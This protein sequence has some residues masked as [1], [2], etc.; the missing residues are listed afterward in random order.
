VRGRGVSRRGG[1]EVRAEEMEWGSVLRNGWV[2][3]DDLEMGHC[4][5]HFPTST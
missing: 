3:L 2:R 4:K 5:I 1:S